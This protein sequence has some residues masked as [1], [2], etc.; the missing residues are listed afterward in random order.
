MNPQKTISK[1]LKRVDEL[2]NKSTK[3]TD[4][5]IPLPSW[6]EISPTDFCNRKCLFCP[7]GDDSIAPNQRLE[8]P[9]QLCEKIATE[10]KDLN[11]KGTVML[12]GY[13]E[14]MAA[15]NLISAINT[16]SAVCNTEITTDG[17]YLTI[18][19][20][21]EMVKAGI[22]KILISMY[23]GEFQIKKFEELFSKSGVG[24]DK[25]VLRDRWYTENGDFG[26]KLTNRAGVV[27]AGHQKEI[28]P[29][30]R[31]FYPHYSMMVDWNGDVFLCTQDW[32]RRIKAGNLN[33]HSLYEVWTSNIM[34]KYRCH[35]YKGER[36]LF[37]CNQ[38]N[39]MGTL[40][41]EKHAEIW[42]SYYTKKRNEMTRS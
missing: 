27:K 3:T 32:H 4:D 34:R 12:A 39:A 8:M 21:N 35:L 29:N 6:I 36:D 30:N 23:D 11:F 1:N 37:P 15:K 26:V 40:H 10:L 19:S 16:F 33:I 24:L 28:N 14:P 38:C 7:K 9:K 5:G 20:I 42:D 17:D 22:G 18:K 25:Y 13:G 2:I 41:G 31:C